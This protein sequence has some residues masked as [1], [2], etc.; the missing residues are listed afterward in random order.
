VQV[1]AQGV[2]VRVWSDDEQRPVDGELAE[3][4]RGGGVGVRGREVR[5]VRE[6]QALRAGRLDTGEVALEGEALAA[7]ESSGHDDVADDGRPARRDV[8]REV[9][10]EPGVG[11]EDGR[12]RDVVEVGIR[13]HFEAH[14]LGRVVARHRLD[15]RRAPGGD[16]GDG[17]VFGGDGDLAAVALGDAAGRGLD[18]HR[19]RARVRVVA[20]RPE[21]W[22]GAVA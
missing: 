22:N 19:R 18:E 3:D 4:A 11:V 5:R 14:G 16:D 17:V 1:V 10:A 7:G 15:L 12:F 21:T 13:P 2:G 6:Q 9:L 20:Q 8:Q